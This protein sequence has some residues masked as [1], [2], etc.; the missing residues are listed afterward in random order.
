MIRIVQ[1]L[2]SPDSLSLIKRSHNEMQDI[3]DLF[4]INPEPFLSQFHFL[5]Y[6][7]SVNERVSAIVLYQIN[8]SNSDIAGAMFTP[9]GRVFSTMYQELDIYYAV[10][11]LSSVE[12]TSPIPQNASRRF[13]NSIKDVAYLTARYCMGAYYF[14]RT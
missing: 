10:R 3:R 11:H 6:P 5:L 7:I 12:T 13:A 9:Q 8:I 1:S 2:L 4:P 14:Y